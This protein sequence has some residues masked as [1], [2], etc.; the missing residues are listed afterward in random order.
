MDA[1]KKLYKQVNMVD[2]S[3]TKSNN[4][5]SVWTVQHWD[6]R[7]MFSQEILQEYFHG[8]EICESRIN[9]FLLMQLSNQI[10]GRKDIIFTWNRFKWTAFFSLSWVALNND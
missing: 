9:V 10:I 5:G 7:Q 2:S 6:W 3:L 8:N 1:S 4:K